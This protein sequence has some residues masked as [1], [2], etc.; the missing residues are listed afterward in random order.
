MGPGRERVLDE[1]AF[2][3]SSSVRLLPSM[4]SAGSTDYDP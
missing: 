3:E 4:S 2:F 1:R